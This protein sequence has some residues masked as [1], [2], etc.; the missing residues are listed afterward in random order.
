MGITL[1]LLQPPPQNRCCYITRAA[2]AGG[3]AT[4]HPRGEGSKE[5]QG[6][7]PHR[8]AAEDCPSTAPIAYSLL[9]P[10]PDRHTKFLFFVHVHP[11]YECQLRE[12][13]KFRFY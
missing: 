3:A 11:N 1:S 4:S 5:E 6:S 2:A 9:A 10:A 8:K 12:I 7:Q 13:M